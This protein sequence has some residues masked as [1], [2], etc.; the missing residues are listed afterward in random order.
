MTKRNEK[1]AI[2]I[3]FGTT[4]SRI[5]FSF[6][7]GKPEILSIRQLPSVQILPYLP[8]YLF[9]PGRNKIIIGEE[10]KKYY[11]LKPH[12]V[13]KSIKRNLNSVFHIGKH[14]YTGKEIAKFI[15]QRLLEELKIT[16][17]KEIHSCVLTVPPTFGHEE[18]ETLRKALEESAKG[19]EELKVMLLDE[20][21]SAFIAHSEEEN[22]FLKIGEGEKKVL[23]I[24]MGGGTTDL[25]ILNCFIRG[26]KFEVSPLSIWSNL[27]LGG[28]DFDK[29]IA[30]HVIEHLLDKGSIHIENLTESEKIFFW[31]QVLYESEKAKREFQTPES[32]ARIVIND[33]AGK[34]LPPST[35]DWEM[36]SKV[37]QPLLNEFSESINYVFERAAMK[38]NDIDTVLLTGGMSRFGILRKAVT[39][40][41]GA[42]IV[43]GKD[44][45]SA[46]ARGACEYHASI[47]GLIPGVHLPIN[48]VITKALFLKLS[49]GSLF[50]ILP[51]CSKL[52][53]KIRIE[54]KLTV[55]LISSGVLRISLYQG[56]DDGKDAKCIMGFS[57]GGK[58][59]LV[60]GKPL[61][62]EIDVDLN[63]MISV[64]ISIDDTLKTFSVWGI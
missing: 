50:K 11:Y 10:A 27:H 43:M 56:S 52:P 18:R 64:K 25:A 4:N 45:Q 54:N 36:M 26:G 31:N 40:S 28:D 22:I 39:D 1:I 55:P 47:L 48:P 16:F 49:G 7:D 41:F 12:R 30:S 2:G 61:T 60:P 63:K 19:H 38:K 37:C 62:M 13:I 58:G 42:K 34:K 14:A 5:C 24:D 3:D 32:R 57:A 15:F 33:P 53:E 6:S 8:G 44:P 29:I 17:R 51:S 35:F 9:F 20:P 21:I 46:V 23:V 59:K